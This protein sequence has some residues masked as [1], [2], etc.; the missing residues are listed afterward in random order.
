MLP[1]ASAWPIL[2][3]P[4]MRLPRP[5]GLPDQASR[6]LAEAPPRAPRALQQIPAPSRGAPRSVPHSREHRAR[7]SSADR[8]VPS[9][10]RGR[11]RLKL[12]ATP[13]SAETI[14]A[15]HKAPSFRRAALVLWARRPE[16]SGPRGTLPSGAKARWLAIALREATTQSEAPHREVRPPEIQAAGE[17][18]DQGPAPARP[19]SQSAR[20]RKRRF[21][22]SGSASSAL[23]TGSSR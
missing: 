18:P 10:V 15:I 20:S 19:R 14:R 4:A 2:L 3:P 12:V 7:L 13:V 16:L 11:L 17:I 21:F 6:R 5:P 9:Q 8:L 23:P 22:P 1:R